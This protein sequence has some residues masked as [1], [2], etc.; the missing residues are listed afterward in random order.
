MAWL[1]V[2]GLIAALSGLEEGEEAEEEVERTGEWWAWAPLFHTSS[3][4]LTVIFQSMEWE[5]QKL[6]HHQV[7]VSSIWHTA[8]GAEGFNP[9]AVG[10][11]GRW[12]PFAATKAG[13]ALTGLQWMISM[14]QHQSLFKNRALYGY[15]GRSGAVG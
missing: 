6:L 13:P 10:C 1:P 7:R 11:A 5:L 4:A 12:I 15:K 14:Q 8:L 3:L 2:H 9:V